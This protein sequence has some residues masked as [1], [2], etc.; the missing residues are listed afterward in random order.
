MLIHLHEEQ[1]GLAL[2][3]SQCLSATSASYSLLLYMVYD[4]YF[5]SGGKLKQRR[6]QCISVFNRLLSKTLSVCFYWPLI[7]TTL[8]PGIILLPENDDTHSLV[9]LHWHTD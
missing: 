7:S 8:N 6:R 1:A 3:A 2:M 9:I 4:D 5:M